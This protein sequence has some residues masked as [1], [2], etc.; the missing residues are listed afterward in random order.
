MWDGTAENKPGGG[1]GCPHSCRKRVQV[2]EA[3]PAHLLGLP[4]AESL[5]QDSSFLGI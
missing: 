1:E 2:P 4:L 3:C 5:K